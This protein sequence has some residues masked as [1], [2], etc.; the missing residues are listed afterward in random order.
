MMKKDK[1]LAAAKLL[2]ELQ[3]P[4]VSDLLRP[5]W[6]KWYVHIVKTIREGRFQNTNGNPLKTP[7]LVALKL[8][9]EKDPNMESFCTDVEEMWG[10]RNKPG[11]VP[12]SLIQSKA[13]KRREDEQGTSGQR[14][15][16]QQWYGRGNA[17]SSSDSGW[18]QQN[19]WGGASSSSWRSTWDED[20]WPQHWSG[21]EQWKRKR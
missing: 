18:R 15:K 17:W 3:R 5:R 21:R 16:P 8:L 10:D 12:R 2:E 9:E 11:F 13:L 20:Q 19:S 14:S 7:K 4:V 1:D 6:W